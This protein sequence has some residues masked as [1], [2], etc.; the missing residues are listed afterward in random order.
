[1]QE[2][3]GQS[4]GQGQL[5]GQGQCPTS[6]T[7]ESGTS[8]H[9]PAQKLSEKTEDI[10]S[11]QMTPNAPHSIPPPSNLQSPGLQP[12]NLHP[13]GNY[14]PQMVR[15][16]SGDVMCHG[17]SISQQ[18]PNRH[19]MPQMYFQPEVSL[20]QHP[21]GASSRENSSAMRNAFLAYNQVSS[22]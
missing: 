3:Q 12:P 14:I 10:G 9:P 20:Q 5:I 13:P 6:S 22:R 17:M 15:S 8:Q 11:Q 19:Q 21:G 4:V 2:S 18:I 16:P 7:A 1:M